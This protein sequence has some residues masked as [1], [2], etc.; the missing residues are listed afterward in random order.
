MDVNPFAAPLWIAGLIAFFLSSRYRML[1]WMY[2]LPVVLFWINKGRF[3]YVAE[4]YPALVAMGAVV[5]VRWLTVRSAYVRNGVEAAFFAGLVFCGG[6]FFAGWVPLASGG[7]LRDFALSKSSDLREE[8]GWDDLVKAVAGIRDSLPAD[9]SSN[10]GIL[11]DNYGEAGAIEN[12]GPAYHLPPPISLTNSFYLRTYPKQQPS[13]LIVVGWSQRRVDAEFTS[14]RLAGHNGNSL[15][16]HNEES[17]DEPDIFVCGP[18]R[19]G[20]PEFW[21]T[22]QRFG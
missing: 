21:R 12:L 17:D 18:P 6:Y 5:A 11:V 10:V 15:G 7:S 8:F 22:N 19:K 16:I 13:T 1:A 20:W 3:Y 14:C 2:V 9:Q 4:A